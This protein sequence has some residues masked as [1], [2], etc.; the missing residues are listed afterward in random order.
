MKYVIT[1]FIL[2]LMTF[3]GYAQLERDKVLHFGIGALCGIGGAIL[4]DELSDGNRFWV[5]TGAVAGSLLAGTAKEAL[6]EQQ[7]NAWDN[8]DLAA[9]VLGGISVGVTIELFSGKKKRAR[10]QAKI[11]F[12]EK[13]MG[14]SI[15]QTPGF[16]D[17][18]MK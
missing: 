4:A 14:A 3:Q 17:F 6:D 7:N 18:S 12:Y 11:A 15:D 5:F 10:Q 1:L 2:T 9:T 16:K 8:G 13:T